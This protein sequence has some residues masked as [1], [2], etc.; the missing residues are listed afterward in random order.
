MI[1]EWRDFLISEVAMNKPLLK[2]LGITHVL[3]AA[4]GE[5]FSQ[6]NTSPE[7][8][9]DLDIKFMGVSLMDV[10]NCRIERHFNDGTRFIYEALSSRKGKN[11][12]STFCVVLNSVN[13]KVK[14]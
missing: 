12:N 8:Y 4:K 3:N 11:R 2:S 1:N 10:D 14:F 6:V 5:K 7:Y 13:F 9:K